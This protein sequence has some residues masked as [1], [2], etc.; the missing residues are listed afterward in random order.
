M[1]ED[2]LWFFFYGSEK[3]LLKSNVD[4][5]KQILEHVKHLLVL[6]NSIV[7]PHNVLLGHYYR[8]M[9]QMLRLV[10]RANFWMRMKNMSMPSNLEHN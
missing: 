10:E 8:H 7:K 9:Y 1:H 2:S 4:E 6:S 5:E 3:F